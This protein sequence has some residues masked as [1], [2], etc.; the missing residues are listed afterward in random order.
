MSP[1]QAT[2]HARYRGQR[3]SLH[4]VWTVDEALAGLRAHRGERQEYFDGAPVST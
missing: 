2:W 4:E 3:G 1:A